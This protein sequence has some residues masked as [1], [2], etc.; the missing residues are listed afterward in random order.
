[1]KD[2][3]AEA[4]GTSGTT[5]AAETAAGARTTPAVKP[6]I[7]VEEGIRARAEEEKRGV[8]PTRAFLIRIILRDLWRRV[9]R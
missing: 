9:P 5:R 8:D 6:A 4:D 1:M 7:R 3:A 2:E